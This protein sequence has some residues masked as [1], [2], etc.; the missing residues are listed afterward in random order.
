MPETTQSTF[1]LRT[2]SSLLEDLMLSSYPGKITE[3]QYSREETEKGTIYKFTGLNK[4]ELIS[5][6]RDYESSFLQEV[7][8]YIHDLQGTPLRLRLGG[9][10]LNGA[11]AIYAAHYIRQNKLGFN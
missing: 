10:V 9:M 2:T 11:N 3:E 5:F 1:S 7:E 6:L 4:N 8:Y